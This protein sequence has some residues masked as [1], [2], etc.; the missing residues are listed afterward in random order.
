MYVS[1]APLLYAELFAYIYIYISI[2]A[3]VQ[4][5]R[6][7]WYGVPQQ[8]EREQHAD[9][10]AVSLP[11]HLQRS[12]SL[13]LSYLISNTAL[14][15]RLRLLNILQDIAAVSYILQFKLSR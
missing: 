14:K 4:Y 3:V 15:A 7:V 13:P 5:Q 6:A 11:T 8:C 9:F 10:S 1:L 12:L 2:T